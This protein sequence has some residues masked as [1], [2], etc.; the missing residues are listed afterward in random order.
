[1]PTPGVDEESWATILDVN[2]TGTLRGCQVFGELMVEER[3][4]RIINIASL[5]SFTAFQEVA[6]YGASEASVAALTRSLAVEW[7]PFG[8]TVNAMAPGIFP[9][10]LKRQ[11]LARY[12]SSRRDFRHRKAMRSDWLMRGI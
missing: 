6:A 10:S 11:L 9:T 12:P 7:S 8:V 1:M 2:L 3:F 4:G 5:T